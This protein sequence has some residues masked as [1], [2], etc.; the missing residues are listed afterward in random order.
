[1]NNR[2][3][4]SIK[5]SNEYI[6]NLIKKNKPF[7]ISRIR[8]ES[9]IVKKYLT[10]IPV[11]SSDIYNLENNSGI[12]LNKNNKDND[13]ISYII[14][15]ID[16]YKN[17]DS[18]LCFDKLHNKIQKFFLK[19]FSLNRI[20]WHVIEP[21][22]L[23]QVDGIKP[24]THYLLGKKVLIISPFIFS[25]KKQLDNNF[26]MY[27]DKDIFLEGQQFI[28]YKCFQTSAGNHL[29]SSW[30]KTFNIMCKDIKKFNFDIALL[31]CG[32]YG[33]PLSYFIHNKL[34]KSAIYIG[35]NLQLYFGVGGKR[36]YKPHLIPRVEKENGCKFIRP[37]GNELTINR[38]RVEGGCY[39]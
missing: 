10:D 29:H 24:W 11:S 16:C 37:S 34:K 14:Y 27:K 9:V 1:M 39:W 4:N 20:D 8:S 25:F 12:Y 28:F 3:I 13:I 5:K 7:I 30:I 31:S 19:Q 15:M 32:G 18:L 17:S 21:F 26:K 33:E 22:R 35:A 38:N 23:F 6:I 36:W 2:K